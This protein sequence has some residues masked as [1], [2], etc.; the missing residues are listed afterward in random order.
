MDLT[1]FVPLIKKQDLETRI[2]ELED[3]LSNPHLY[4]TEPALFDSCARELETLK[5]RLEEKETLW[6]ELQIKSES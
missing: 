5:K 3:S 6:L 2:K 4:Q 1:N